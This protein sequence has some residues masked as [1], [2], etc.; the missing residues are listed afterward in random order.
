MNNQKNDNIFFIAKHLVSDKKI[1]SKLKKEAHILS[2]EQKIDIINKISSEKIMLNELN[3]L[4]I[5]SL[6]AFLPKL[7]S[8]KVKIQLLKNIIKGNLHNFEMSLL[9]AVRTAIVSIPPETLF[10]TINKTD[11]DNVISELL[12]YIESDEIKYKG[13]DKLKEEDYIF[14]LLK[15]IA[16]DE[17]KYEGLNRLRNEDYIC[18]ILTTMNSE[19]LKYE[20]L[21]RLRNEDYIF[22]ILQR[23]DSDEIKFEWINRLQDQRYKHDVAKNIKS[24]AIKIKLLKDQSN[25]MDKFELLCSMSV[26]DVYSNLEYMLENNLVTCSMLIDFVDDKFYISLGEK[27]VIKKNRELLTNGNIEQQTLF[28][29]KLFKLS[30]AIKE[31]NSN[32]MANFASQIFD[33]ILDS[34]DF[35]VKL[36][37]IESIFVKNNIPTVGKKFSIF[38]IL[39][40]SYHKFIRDKLSPVLKQYKSENTKDIIIFSDLLRI[41][42]GSNN[43]VLLKYI[44]NIEE[45]NK[46]YLNVLNDVKVIE[47]LSPVEKQVLTEFLMHIRTLYENTKSGQKK[48][49]K[50]LTG[51]LIEDITE[52]NNL[53]LKEN[54]KNN[55][56]PDKIIRMFFHFSG[57][58]TLESLKTYCAQK[59]ES[60]DKK[61]RVASNSEFKIQKGDLVKGV[62]NIEYLNM[63]LQNGS[64]SKEFLGESATSDA[65]PL[66]TDLS[67]CLHSF[68]TPEKAL[69]NIN[70]GFYGPIFFVLKNDEKFYITRNS[71]GNEKKSSAKDLSKLELF[72]TGVNGLDHYGI[73]TGFSS[74]DIDYVLVKREHLIS[75]VAL[76]IVKNGFYI[77]IVNSSGKL[78]LTPNEYDELRS[79]MAGLSEYNLEQ[80]SIDDS[81][82]QYVNAEIKKSVIENMDKTLQKKK[83]VVNEIRETMNSFDLIL[84]DHVDNDLS[85]GIYELIDT[86]STGRFTNMPGDGDFDFI[87]RLDKSILSNPQKVKEIKDKLKQKFSKCEEFVITAK[88]DFRIK[89]AKIYGL[90]ESVDIDITFAQKTDKLSYTTDMC[91]LDRLNS[92]KR[93]YPVKYYDIIANIVLAKKVLK[94]AGIYKARQ[95]NGIGGVGVENWILQNNGSMYLAFKSFL[96]KSQG[97]SLEEFKKYYCVWDFGENYMSSNNKYPHDNFIELNLTENSYQKMQDTLKNYIYKKTSVVDE[98]D[99]MVVSEDVVSITR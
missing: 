35:E 69:L 97:K 42:A 49:L 48:E 50:N 89:K 8:D 11:S 40:G 86:G 94:E 52:I 64:V 44:K 45:G 87:M 59:I 83:S 93:Q 54:I 26:E 72:Y 99:E 15:T 24:P 81:I 75:K 78:C 53:F 38:K 23:I 9:F 36:K 29:K 77:P 4:D 58:D 14:S 91:L 65:T 10:E 79:K 5:P 88:G 57:I 3:K 30:Q 21:N 61:N 74:S 95:E 37:K 85:N 73:R 82:D 67:M 92:I 66:D 7:K 80:Y 6:L 63:I 18:S 22:S 62:G 34:E 76:E 20:G 17:L 39:N 12:S 56:L 32:E 2:T 98:L 31:S 41:T 70:A 25:Y 46:L 47:Q 13:L 71:D 68:E 16:S 90:E 27:G 28:M 60:S 84:K 55:D 19:E 51:D 43:R 33:N 1:S 96:E